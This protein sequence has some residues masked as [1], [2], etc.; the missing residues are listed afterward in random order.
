VYAG[1]KEHL[2]AKGIRRREAVLVGLHRTDVVQV[3]REGADRK[4]MRYCRLHLAAHTTKTAPVF[5]PL[6]EDPVFR[7]VEGEL[8]LTRVLDG[9]NGI[10]KK[11]IAAVQKEWVDRGMVIIKDGV[12]HAVPVG[13]RTQ[14]APHTPSVAPRMAPTALA[15]RV[16]QVETD[17]ID[18]AAVPVLQRALGAASQAENEAVDLQRENKRLRLEIAALQEEASHRIAPLSYD[19]LTTGELSDVC[20]KFGALPAGA[21]K[22]LVETCVA[23]GMEEAWEESVRADPNCAVQ[24]ILQFGFKNAVAL[25]LVRMVLGMKAEVLGWAFGVSRKS[26]GTIFKIT[27]IVVNYAMSKTVARAPNVTQMDEDQLDAFKEQ[28]LSYVMLTADASNI[29]TQKTQNPV[30]DKHSFSDYYG[31]NC[32]KFELITGIDGLP[33]FTTPA[34]GGNASEEAM[35]RDSDFSKW[36]KEFE[37]LCVDADGKHFTPTMMADKGT[38]I[39][40]LMKE[41][42]GGY[43][44]PS[45]VANG[46][47]TSQ[48]VLSNEIIAKARGHVE[49]AIMLVKRCKILTS[50]ALTHSLLP[51]ID[52]IL[53]FAVFIIH[54]YPKTK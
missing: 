31:R 13:E 22:A 43:L 35:L 54:F 53:Y 11:S 52:E 3:E 15:R 17:N 46:F 29:T 25:T 1:P 36:Y 32:A 45:R 42:G 49:R 39:G 16:L 5:L 6:A 12:L 4:Q 48:E 24:Q 18:P 28:V 30:G 51:M 37:L 41:L 38:M 8:R 19:V 50:G 10:M 26:V 21:L 9:R 40:P 33:V 47:V 2:V 20:R 34:F 27:L 44:T 7:G 23:V 14:R